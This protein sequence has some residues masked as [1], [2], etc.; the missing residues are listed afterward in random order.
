M[1][2]NDMRSKLT[3]LML[4][5][6][7]TVCVPTLTA[8]GQNQSLSGDTFLKQ[9]RQMEENI[10]QELDKSLP[11]TQRVDFDYGGWLSEYFYLFDDGEH[12]SRTLRQTDLRLWSSF[13]LDQGIHSGYVRMK[14]TYDDWNH[15]DLDGD[16]DDMAGPN[17]ERGWYELN[18]TKLLAKYSDVTLPV[19]FSTRIGRDYLM[20]G[21]GYA[22]SMPLDAVQ[23]QGNV[24]KL[25]I[26]G[27]LGRTIHS[28]DN[29][30]QSRPNADLSW[31]YFYG[32]QTRFTG[33][34]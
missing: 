26:D 8:F 27:L 1:T 34:Q 17:L 9:Q 29:V 22:L 32:V 21:T 20:W 5:V 10:R 25:A 4:A 6:A 28:W 13:N 11:D 30:D 2:H 12:S 14:A 16:E 24:G 19:D 7:A 23:F 3:I 33:F 31:R 18:L 15:G